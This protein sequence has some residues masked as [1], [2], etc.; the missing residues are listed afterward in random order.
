MYQPAKP[1]VEFG[2][3]QMTSTDDLLDALSRYDE[4]L[5]VKAESPR[6]KD[7]LALSA[8]R[9]RIASTTPGSVTLDDLTQLMDYKLA[10]GKWRPRLQALIRENEAEGVVEASTEAYELLK[11][12]DDVSGALARL[13]KL[14]GIGPATSSLVLSI[15]R[16]AALPFFSDELA[17]VV[18]LPKPIKYTAK[19]YTE[20]VD[21]VKARMAA[22]DRWTSAEDFEKAAYAYTVLNG[23]SK[24]RSAPESAEPK[25]KRKKA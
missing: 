2:C 10:R 24:K 9:D 11:D 19:E 12:S 13:S 15:F 6:S 25:A 17:A 7:L 23:A 20:L 5:C 4:A 1:L 21:R 3:L 22:D 8:S 16:P 18:D 14:R